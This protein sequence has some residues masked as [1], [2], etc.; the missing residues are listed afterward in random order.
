MLRTQVQLPEEQYEKLKALAATR[1][2]SISELVRQGVELLLSATQRDD[3]WAR[4]WA[5]IG[6]GRDPHGK[7]DHVSRRHDDVLVSM[8]GHEIDIH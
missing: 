7:R 2:Q 3:L 5:A 1:H 8:Y 6:S 4:A